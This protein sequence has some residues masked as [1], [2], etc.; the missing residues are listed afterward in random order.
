MQYSQDQNSDF[1]VKDH[2]MGGVRWELTLPPEQTRGNG[3]ATTGIAS[4][5]G[6]A[7][8][9][10]ENSLIVIRRRNGKN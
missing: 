1:V 4:D 5:R 10:A 9:Q 2:A 3:V 8:K 7:E 6:L